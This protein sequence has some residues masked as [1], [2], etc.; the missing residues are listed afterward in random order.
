MKEEIKIIFRVVL[1]VLLFI[2]IFIMIKATSDY[3]SCNFKTTEDVIGFENGEYTGLYDVDRE[4][5]C[6]WTQ[7][8]TEQEIIKTV[9]H[10]S[11]HYLVGQD[12][13]HYCEQND[14]VIIK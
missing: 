5:F 6:V 10:E 12:R 1:V 14:V 3:D 13:E 7:N 8:R 4:Y 11:C 2:N 9:Y